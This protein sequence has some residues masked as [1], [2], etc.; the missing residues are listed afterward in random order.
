[1]IDP[2]GNME[3]IDDIKDVALQHFRV[4]LNTGTNTDFLDPDLGFD[5]RAVITAPFVDTMGYDKAAMVELS[6]V[7]EQ[8]EGII[9][10]ISVEDVEV[11]GTNLKIYITLKLPG[12]IYL[13]TTGVISSG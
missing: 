13:K 12:D 1:M 2:D 10:N 9:E 5:V 8:L 6:K 11:D 7:P 4:W 3:W